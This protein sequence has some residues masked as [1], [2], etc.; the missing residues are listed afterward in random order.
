MPSIYY[1]TLACGIFIL[2]LLVITI[3]KGII[4]TCILALAIGSAILTWIFLQKHGLTYLSLAF[5]APAAWLVNVCS[6][7][8]AFLALYAVFRFSSMLAN[9][10]RF[11]SKSKSKNGIIITIGICLLMFWVAL[12]GFSYASN[13]S[14][15]QYHHELALAHNTG[16]DN[17][18]EPILMRAK[19]KI[20]SS[21]NMAWILRLDP[22]DDPSLSNLACIVA[23][24]STLNKTGQVAFY[25]RHLSNRNIPHPT[26]FRTLFSDEG[27]QKTVR[28]N[29]FVSLMENEQ[30]KTFL[31]LGDTASKLESIL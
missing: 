17:P 1:I 27:I 26:R 10:F 18:T 25:N 9:I 29:H 21:S 23:Y 12:M 2:F 20:L 31:Q 8:G 13:I 22:I 6:Y 5:D 16:E 15:I 3:I 19:N 30:L 14:R 7:L 28:E 11:T 24:G 4:K